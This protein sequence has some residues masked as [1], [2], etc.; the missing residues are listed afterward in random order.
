MKVAF[1]GDFINHGKFLVSTGTSIVLLLSE[2][3]DVETIDV[4]CPPMNNKTEYFK[5]PKKVEVF[6]S[7]KYDDPFS[8]ITLLKIRKKKL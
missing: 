5:K 8:I 6:E 7:Y 1:V 3:P 4:Y 2:V